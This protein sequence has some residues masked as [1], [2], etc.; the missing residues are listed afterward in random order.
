MF[1]PIRIMTVTVA[2]VAAMMVK[3]ARCHGHMLKS[4]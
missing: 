3:A 1:C 4:G 2:I